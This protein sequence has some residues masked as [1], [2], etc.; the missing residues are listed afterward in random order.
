MRLSLPIVVAGMI[1]AMPVLAAAQ[2]EGDAPPG[3]PPDTQQDVP[4]DTPPAIPEAAVAPEL[5][6]EAQARYDA[7]PA[8]VRE[9]YDTADARQQTYVWALPPGR[10]AMFFALTPEDRDTLIAME[11][12]AQARAWAMIE[13]H[14]AQ[15]MNPD[16]GIEDMPDHSGP[17]PEAGPVTV[18]PEDIPEPVEPATPDPGMR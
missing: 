8:Q 10:A 4:P 7:W 6:P 1:L 17:D 12:E 13:E 3:M 2:Q 16:S 15:L 9:R 5:T 11:P 18:D 14:H